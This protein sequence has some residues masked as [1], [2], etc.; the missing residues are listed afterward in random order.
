VLDHM[1]MEIFRRSLKE[2][3][4]VGDEVWIANETGDFAFTVFSSSWTDKDIP[5]LPNL[6]FVDPRHRSLALKR[7]NAFNRHGHITS[8]SPIELQQSIRIC[9]SPPR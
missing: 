8:K 9:S 2:G 4:V 1:A 3:V 7:S 5:S 6:P